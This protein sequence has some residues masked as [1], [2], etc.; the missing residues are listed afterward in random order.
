MN[1]LA[2]KCYFCHYPSVFVCC[3]S[4]ICLIDFLIYGVG[5]FFCPFWTDVLIMYKVK[6]E[7]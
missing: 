1:Y 6:D 7:T 4:K 2:E 5:Y 3:Y